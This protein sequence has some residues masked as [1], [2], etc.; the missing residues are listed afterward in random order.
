MII[1][2]FGAR[3]ASVWEGLRPTTRKM[4]VGALQSPGTN[5]LPAQKH[6]PLP[7]DAR[8]DWELS[9]L[10]AALDERIAESAS[11]LSVE[12]ARDLRR[13]AETCAALLQNQAQSAEVFAQLVTR[14]HRAHDFARIDALADALSSRFA[15]SEICELARQDHPVVRALA[16]EALAQSPTGTLVSLLADPVDTDIARDALER[17]A[18]EYGNEGARQLVYML[19]QADMAADEEDDA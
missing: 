6:G 9:R 8:S 11:T 19:D 17:Q 4:I 5:P 15:P 14:A 12:Q 2:D 18:I 13:M 3:I 10:L 1:E 7:N 16:Q